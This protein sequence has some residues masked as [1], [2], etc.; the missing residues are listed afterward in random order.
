VCEILL[1]LRSHPHLYE[2]NTWPWLE[3]LSSRSGRFVTL[4]S[5][6]DEQWDRL[7]HRGMDLVYLMG[8]WRRSAIGRE[9]A[10]GERSIFPAYDAAR[11]GW[12]PRDVVGSAYSIAAYEPDPRIGGWDAVDS[13]REKLHARGMQLVLDF[14]PNHL[15][16]DH[17]WIAGHTD[18]FVSVDDTTF[19][20]SP[21]SYREVQLPDGGVRFIACGRDPYFPPWTDVAQLNYFNPDTRSA[22][23]AELAAIA[24][25]ADGAR[26]DMAMLVLSD[27]FAR[28]WGERSGG[29]VGPFAVPATEFWSEA[30]TAVPNLLLLAEVY[31]DLE[32][33]LQQLGFD[34]TY[35][36][37]LYDRLRDGSAAEVRGHLRAEA[38][39]QRKSAR[40]IENHDEARSVIAFGVRAEAAAVAGS[41]VPG[42]RFYYDGQFEGH[43]IKAPVQ[44][45][46]VDEEPVDA[47]V[48][49]RYGRLL[50][51]VDAPVFHDGDWA[52]CEA[53]ASDL[54]AWRWRLGADLRL[55]VVCLGAGVSQ[56]RVQI[57]SELPQGEAFVFE[58]LLDGSR[59]EY[60]RG[61]L[62]KAGLYV[63][64]E[65]G[66][67]HVFAIMAREGT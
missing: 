30:R 63:R 7:Q 56:G 13:V 1:R 24:Q 8:I 59:Y 58:D 55:V 34:F 65:P 5:V 47:A 54:I 60:A 36:K 62:E 31:W 26:C 45:G 32:W 2:I 53:D 22:M 23:L 18:R 48:S 64:L 44:L 41:T 19:R 16:F 37:R 49:E 29:H 33:R 25:H 57:A 67:A 10:Q 27:V 4:S 11:P 15:G 6:P 9:I 35:D 38:E 17:P 28:T 20:R 39:Y 42:M 50:P 43:R 14:I 61:E 40:F 21:S 52:L 12:R 46:V 3:S 66:R 51:I